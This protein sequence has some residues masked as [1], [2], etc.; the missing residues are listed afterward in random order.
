METAASFEARFAPWSYPTTPP[1]VQKLQTALHEMWLEAPV[2]ETDER[3]NTN[4]K[5]E[6]GNCLIISD[7]PHEKNPRIA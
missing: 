3:G 2:E 6:T 1:S 7:S 5:P 4:G